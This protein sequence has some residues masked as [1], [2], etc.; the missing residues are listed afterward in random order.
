MEYIV[1][2]TM[3]LI[4]AGICFF[5]AWLGYR[6]GQK[7]SKEGKTPYYLAVPERRRGSWWFWW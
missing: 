1:L 4:G 3:M 6:Y 2:I 7:Q 5:I